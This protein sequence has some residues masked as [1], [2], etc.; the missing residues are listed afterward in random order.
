MTL[1]SLILISIALAM[2]SF[3]VS[4]SAGLAMKKVK[5][6]QM[7]KISLLFALFQGVMP[8]IGWLA[9]VYFEPYINRFDHWIAFILLSA[10]GGKM[11]WEAIDKQTDAPAINPYCNRTL[12]TLA[13]ATSIDALAIGLSFSILNYAI[14]V[15]A[16]V[17]GLI[18]FIFS[19]GGLTLGVK[20][21]NVCGTKI[22]LAGGIILV[23]I[24]IKIVIEHLSSC[25]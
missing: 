8:I 13:F 21:G 19:L 1:L 14:L 16:F 11:I 22:E 10:I 12:T 5:I 3:A 20:L 23:G 18:T 25:C 4:I 9:G 2:D 6:R 7:G 17:I 24:G 15:P